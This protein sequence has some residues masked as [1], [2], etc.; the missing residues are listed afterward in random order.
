MGRI[1][2]EEKDLPIMIGKSTIKDKKGTFKYVFK[3]VCGKEFL[4]YKRSVETQRCKSCGC[5][6]NAFISQ[7]NRGSV[8]KNRKTPTDISVA[9]IFYSSKYAA[10]AKG[11]KFLLTRQDV[12]SLIF[13]E[14]FY[15]GSQ[16]SRFP[17]R[18]R[19]SKP[20]TIPI[21]G[22]DR[23]DNNEGY[24]IQNCVPCCSDC[25]YLKS[26]RHGNRFIKNI[27]DIH[28]HLVKKGFI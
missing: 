21:N 17:K 18:V 3:C 1:L 2:V 10:K 11:F 5:K 24:I 6:T 22:I 9:Y 8:P 12:E 25:N 7:A 13:K 26:S 14:C 4:T 16:P 15:C 23:F 27:K 20:L 19:D 28:E